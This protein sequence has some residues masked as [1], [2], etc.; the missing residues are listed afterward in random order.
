MTSKFDNVPS[1]KDTSIIFQ[2]EA[3]FDEFDILYQKWSFDGISAESVIFCND[4]VSNL[5]DSEI[6]EHVK[7]SPLLKKGSST[8]LKRS[9][10]GYT[11]V[12]FNFITD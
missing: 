6:T 12:N 3:K 8:T 10:S 11:F 1:D 9:D 4:D 7:S 5:S 2:T